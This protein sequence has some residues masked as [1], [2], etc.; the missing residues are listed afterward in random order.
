[1]TLTPEIRAEAEAIFAAFR[2]A[3]AAPVEADILQPAETFLDLYGE[4]VRARAYVTADPLRG[5][6]MLRPDF[7][8]PVARR[9]LRSEPGGHIH[10]LPIACPRTY[11]HIT[12]L[13]R[14][15][16][17]GSFPAAQ[18]FS[19]LPVLA[20]VPTATTA[21]SAANSASTPCACPRIRSR[22]NRRCSVA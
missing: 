4:D 8:V 19:C 16:M 15:T 21:Q 5:E 3:G 1:M 10:G 9:P 6:M 17:A 7:T 13:H 22:P 18:R 14:P 12:G 2:A 20:S 11:P